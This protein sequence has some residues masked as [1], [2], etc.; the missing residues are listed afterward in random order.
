MSLPR[1]ERLEQVFNIFAYSKKHHN[2][3]MIYDPSEPF[4]DMDHLPREDWSHSIYASG[5]TKLSKTLPSD[6]PEARG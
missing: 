6:A 4:I 5:G 1:Y 3:G 2:T